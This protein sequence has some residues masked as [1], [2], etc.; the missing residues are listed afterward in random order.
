VSCGA[1]AVTETVR[2]GS[3]RP[4]AVRHELV[5]FLVWRS[6]QGVAA[7]GQWSRWP[8]GLDQPHGSAKD[9]KGLTPSRRKRHL[10]RGASGCTR[11]LCD[12]ISTRW[13]TPGVLYG[14]R[15]LRGGPGR[16]RVLAE[17]LAQHL[18]A[19]IKGPGEAAVNAGRT[20]ARSP[21]QLQGGD[22]AGAPGEHPMS[23]Q[24]AIAA[25]VRMLG[26]MVSPRRSAPT[27]RSSTCTGATLCE[28]AES[29]PD[30]VCGADLGS[31][32]GPTPSSAAWSTPPRGAWSVSPRSPGPSR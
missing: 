27:A 13:L 16:P 17:V 14:A 25:V 15:K 20:W 29:N 22:G 4:P 18:L 9:G 28:L 21:G 24:A 6:A 32:R 26:T 19:T 30:V 2:M 31:C 10:S 3:C 12:P 5:S 1:R 8:L 11:S 7:R 23:E